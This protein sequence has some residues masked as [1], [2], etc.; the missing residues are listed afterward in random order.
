[1]E[2]RREKLVLPDELVLKWR[3]AI[4]YIAKR[5]RLTYDKI[6][7]IVGYDSKYSIV[8]MMCRK[9]CHLSPIQFLA[10]IKIMEEIVEKRPAS[11]NCKARAQK[12]LREL[13]ED[14]QTLLKEKK[15]WN[16]RLI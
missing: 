16:L 10:I 15:R 4:K 6:S 2:S 14:Y 12:M 3:E 1:M 8:N 11:E 13:I 9:D 7:Q 5:Y